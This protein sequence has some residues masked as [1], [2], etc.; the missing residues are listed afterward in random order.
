MQQKESNNVFQ[1]KYDSLMKK[2]IINELT[3][4]YHVDLFSAIIPT[5]QELSSAHNSAHTLIVNALIF[6]YVTFF[7]P[8]INSETYSQLFEG[9][10]ICSDDY[11]STL[12]ISI[13]EIPTICENI[14]ID[15]LNSE[16]VAKNNRLI[17]KKSKKNL[18]ET[19]SVYTLDEIAYSIVER[20][21]SNVVRKE[22]NEVRVLDFAT[23]TGRFYRQV[24]RYFSER[25]GISVDA[26]IVNNVYAVDI[27][28]TA[29]NICRL[30]AFSMLSL[31]SFDNL[32][33][34]ASH[35]LCK[36]A[37]IRES[38]FDKADTTGFYS[39]KF[40]AIVSNP[41]YLVLKPN[42]SKMD[43][44]T[45]DHINQMA[46]YFRTS[47]F[48]NYSIERM[49]NLYQLSLEAML[50]MLQPNGEMGIICPS[51]L[52]ADISA[53]KL[54]KHFL[55][56]HR[57]SFIKYF[58]EDDP[59]FENVTQATCI[60]HL[61][62]NGT[63][64]E[65]EIEQQGKLTHISLS[66]VKHLMPDNWEIPSIQQIEWSILRKLKFFP[67]L[68]DNKSIR[69]KRGELDL[70]FYKDYIT[71]SKTN[72][73][74]VRGNMIS[75]KGLLDCNHEYVI[76][77]FLLCKSDEY[78]QFDFGHKRLICQQIS[79]QMQTVRLR[80]VL[81]E[82]NDILGNSCNYI[83]VDNGLTNRI[84]VILNSALLNWRFKITS[85]NNHIN[86]YELDELPI[87]NLDLVDESIIN[88]DEV[89]KNR[90][91]CKLYGLSEEETQFI[92]ST[93]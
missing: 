1:E 64:D 53:T 46:Q 25:C 82:E 76:P 44:N 54:R 23:G 73:R 16:Y 70:S 17:K 47:G 56:S 92:M 55:S 28:S 5:E 37:L 22:F 61:T 40:D 72:Y 83:S 80:F 6:Q 34:I 21:L 67:R 41:P 79:N 42:K 66:D 69:N 90:E 62:K 33:V 10:L 31:K 86:N 32:K 30:R 81:C 77:D 84:M 18:L 27:D 14:H 87:I 15:F 50:G 36:N 85:T 49:L 45:I 91:V 20:T 35:I 3:S 89:S 7:C 9:D 65:I 57:V 59:L 58:T 39:F 75:S 43:N 78:K 38:L 52:F 48:Y 19:G 60:F 88:L 8:I 12:G 63:T 93:I 29:V 71:T 2:M 68:K 4:L 74:L 26:S 24:I 51:T 13:N 11:A